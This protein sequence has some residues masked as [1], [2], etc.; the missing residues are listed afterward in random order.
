MKTLDAG[1]I[2][3]SNNHS[4]GNLVAV[5]V[6]VTLRAFGALTARLA[7]V[8]CQPRRQIAANALNLYGSALN[9]RF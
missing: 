8:P 4:D 6:L 1:M 3:H 5:V 2:L 7:C 9:G